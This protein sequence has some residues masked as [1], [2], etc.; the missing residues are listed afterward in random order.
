MNSRSLLT[1]GTLFP[2][3]IYYCARKWKLSLVVMCPL[4]P[5]IHVSTAEPQHVQTMAFRHVSSHRVLPPFCAIL[6][7][8]CL[9][10]DWGWGGVGWFGLAHDFILFLHSIFCHCSSNQEQRRNCFAWT[11]E[12]IPC[13]LLCG[14]TDRTKLSCWW[15]CWLTALWILTPEEKVAWQPFTMQFRYVYIYV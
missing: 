13:I 7:G 12:T 2:P 5:K 9:Y 3:P 14:I 10:R 15:S 1:N 11:M 6:Q 4:L 8:D